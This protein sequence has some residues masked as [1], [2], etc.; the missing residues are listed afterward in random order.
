[1]TKQ[2]VMQAGKRLGDPVE[3]PP[4]L[5][6]ILLRERMLNLP[7]ADFLQLSSSLSLAVTAEERER[8]REDSVCLSEVDLIKTRSQTTSLINANDSTRG[9][10][11]SLWRESELPWYVLTDQTMERSDSVSQI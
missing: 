6:G 1:M 4:Y 3:G 8:E 9:D 5:N 11:S 2:D 10:H 7:R